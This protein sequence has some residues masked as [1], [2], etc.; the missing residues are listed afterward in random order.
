[1]SETSERPAPRSEGIPV[2]I[3]RRPEL[4]LVFANHAQVTSTRYEFFLTF[5]QI[6][7]PTI[8]KEEDL[9]ALETI[10]ATPVARVVMSPAL[11]ERLVQILGENYGRF[12]KRQ[13][14]KDK[15]EAVIEAEERGVE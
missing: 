15:D 12:Q 10:S 3:E 8:Q 1:M 11:M 5:S 13:A 2:V 9:A 4:P 14:D 6:V 7:P